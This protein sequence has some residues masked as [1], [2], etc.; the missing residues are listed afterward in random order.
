MGD[1]MTYFEEKC[2]SYYNEEE[3]KKI[4]SGMKKRFT[5]FRINPLKDDGKSLEEIKNLG[6]KV[7]KSNI[8]DNAYILLN[9]NEADLENL[10]CYKNGQIYL[11]S[12]SSMMPPL[13]MD[14]NPGHAILDMA[15]APGGKTTEMAAL[16]MN[17][18]SI[19]ACELNK[20]RAQRLKFNVDLQG[21]SSVYVMNADSRHLDEFFIFDE[22]LLDAPCSG[23]GTREFNLEGLKGLTK[24]LVE[25][26]VKSQELLLKEAFKHLK[27]NGTMVYSTCSIFKCE[28]EEVVLKALKGKNYEIIPISFED[29]NLYL[30]PSTIKG[31]L[32]IMPNE[33]FEGFFMIKI[34]KLN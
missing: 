11:Q 23:S 30:L 6:F 14:L 27:K 8:Y 28:N 7:L 9:G 19:T 12:L 21:A 2:L 31:A 15:A 16:S 20:I 3:V 22:I 34:K 26:S 29:E 17:K 13:K 25:K 1:N 24:E 4:I 5:T 33:Y 32:T 10:S 18:T